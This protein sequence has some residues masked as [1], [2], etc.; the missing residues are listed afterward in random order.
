MAS[1]TDSSNLPLV[2][3]LIANS[4]IEASKPYILFLLWWNEPLRKIDGNANYKFCLDQLKEFKKYYDS[5]RLEYFMARTIERLPEHKQA[6]FDC[7]T[8]HLNHI[9]KQDLIKQLV[10]S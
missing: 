3:E 1:S 6:L 10:V 5:S 4:E 7:F 2:K 8:I 9:S